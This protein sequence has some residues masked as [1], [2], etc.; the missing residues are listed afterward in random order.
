MTAGTDSDQ[1]VF[2]GYKMEYEQCAESYRHTYATIWQAGGLFGVISGAIVAVGSSGDG[3]LDPL[4]QVLAPLPLLFWYLGIFRPMNRY[5]EWRSKR[6]SVLEEEVFPKL[7][8]RLEMLHFSEYNTRRKKESSLYRALTFK[9]IWRPRV[10]E[11]VS[12][13]G[14]SLLVAELVLISVNYL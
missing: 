3:G 4:L 5:G 2:D 12:I 7:E 10:N 8:S 1:R 14:I 13:L 6:L 9:W 11:I